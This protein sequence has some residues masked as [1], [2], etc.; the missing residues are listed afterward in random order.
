[1]TQ[2]EYKEALLALAA[3][4]LG[5]CNID[6]MTDLVELSDRVGWSISESAYQ[7]RINLFQATVDEYFPLT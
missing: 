6:G 3:T 5:M 2:D 7:A 4:S 1:M